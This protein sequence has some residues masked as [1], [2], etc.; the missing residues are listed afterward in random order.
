MAFL[1]II[2]GTH[3]ELAQENRILDEHEMAVETDFEG[4]VRVDDN[5]MKIG[6]G[7]TH[8]NSLPQ[9][10]ARAPYDL[11]RQVDGKPASGAVILRIVARLPFTLSATA[12]QG[13]AATGATAQTDFT[14]AVNGVSKGVLRFAASGTVASVVGGTEASVAIGDVITLTAPSQDSTL[15]DVTFTLA[16]TVA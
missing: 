9:F 7:V 5:V 13:F 14:I 16:G 3:A 8:Y 11:A 1:K 10:N 4:T 2:R 6:D 15:A 12:H